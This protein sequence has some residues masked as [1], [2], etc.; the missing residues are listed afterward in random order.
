MTFGQYVL[1]WRLTRNLTQEQ[2]GQRV[3]VT[4]AMIKQYE[5]NAMMPRYK[6]MMALAETMQVRPKHLVRLWLEQLELQCI[7]SPRG[8]P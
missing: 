4:H 6:V 3:G 2:L 8:S 5:K 7:R 1:H